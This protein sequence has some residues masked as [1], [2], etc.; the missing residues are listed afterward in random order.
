MRLL[1]HFMLAMTIMPLALA[2]QAS[3]Q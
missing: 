3:A 2:P 1:T